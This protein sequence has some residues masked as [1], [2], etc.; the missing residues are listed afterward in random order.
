MFGAGATAAGIC[1]SAFCSSGAALMGILPRGEA[2]VAVVIVGVGK[3][4]SGRGAMITSSAVVCVHIGA[5]LALV[6]E[7]NAFGCKGCSGIGEVGFSIDLP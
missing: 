1:C 2:G 6:G 7:A 5:A 3:P 4:S